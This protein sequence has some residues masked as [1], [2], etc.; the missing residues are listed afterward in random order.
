MEASKH[1]THE[2]VQ[3]EISRGKFL[4]MGLSAAL[5]SSG[6]APFVA[7]AQTVNF[8]A[9]TTGRL[10]AYCRGDG[11]DET[12]QIRKCLQENLFVEIDEPPG[13]VGYGFHIN[14]TDGGLL[15]RSGQEINGRGPTASSCG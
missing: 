9:A 3:A 4:G 15:L 11:S 13:G 14:G 5:L 12:Y 7:K 6:I 1:R 10:S 8:G 2:A